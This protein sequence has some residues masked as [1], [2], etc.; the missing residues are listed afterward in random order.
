[1]GNNPSTTA[2]SSLDT[3]SIVASHNG[4]LPKRKLSRR[5]SNF[6]GAGRLKQA[7]QTGTPNLSGPK[8]IPR[9]IANSLPAPPTVILTSAEASGATAT[10]TNKTGSPS[11]TTIAE[12]KEKITVPGYFKNNYV[13]SDF[14]PTERSKS[15]D[16]K[17]EDSRFGMLTFASFFFFFFF[18][19]HLSKI[20]SYQ[21]LI[22]DHQLL[23]EPHLRS[24]KKKC[25]RT[26]N[27]LIM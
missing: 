4:M 10:A 12:D 5:T 8:N 19:S 26:I 7:R 13:S 20:T 18:F 1:M 22:L 23:R 24:K 27:Q 15:V 11:S 21:Y 16:S 14:I 3:G 6:S 9:V 17:M 2:N 25:T